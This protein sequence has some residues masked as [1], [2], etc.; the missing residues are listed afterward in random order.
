MFSTKELLDLRNSGK[1]PVANLKM[2]ED[3]KHID[4]SSRTLENL[5]Y[6]EEVYIERIN[7]IMSLDEI[8]REKY[9]NKIKHI[10]NA[11]NQ[12]LEQEDYFLI[13]L[14][15]DIMDENPIDYLLDNDMDRNSFIEGH[16][17]I[18]K[19]TSSD[20]LST[21]DYRQND[22]TYVSCK[23]EQGRIIP[24]YFALDHEDIPEAIER[25]VEYYNSNSDTNAFEK[26]I[27]THGLIAGLQLFNDGNTRYARL[28]QY[29]KIHELT[30]K[31]YK[32][33]T[34]KP[35]IYGTRAYFPFRGNYR[36][37]IADLVTHGD[38]DSW[39]SWINFNL[40]RIQDRMD[41]EESKLEKVKTL[42]K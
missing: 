2:F 34:D 33:N 32:T 5:Q 42:I 38:S 26:P 8:I 1:Y 36:K 12:S 11:D 15:Q 40:N 41:Y 37:N 3:I 35:L 4:L 21:I 14:Y 19:G 13:D 20:E 7:K 28:L 31:L 25:I 22:D 17:L 24:Y 23:D 39:N 29:L 10:E 27:I 6:T 9:L 30:N 16:K 18:L